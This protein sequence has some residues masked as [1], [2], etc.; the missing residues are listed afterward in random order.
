MKSL[1]I[2]LLLLSILTSPSVE[3]EAPHLAL[4]ATVLHVTPLPGYSG[5]IIPID[6]APQFAL[7][8]KIESATPVST[9]F[10]IG[11]NVVFAIHSPTRLFA[12]QPVTNRSYDFRLKREVVDGKVVFSDLSVIHGKAK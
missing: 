3:T 10:T 8:L 1:L 2:S 4:R 6:V 5:K 7:V 11:S 9:N 12:D